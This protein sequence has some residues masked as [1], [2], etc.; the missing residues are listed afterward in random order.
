MV[1]FRKRLTGK[2]AKKPTD[3]VSLYATLDRAHDKGPLRPAQEAVLG[4]WFAKRQSERDVIIKLH[5]GQGKTL[6]G[7]LML[8]SRLNAG[9]GPVVY[10]CP[11]NFLIEQTEEQARQFGI[12]T[13]AADGELP[14]AFLNADPDANSAFGGTRHGP[15][16]TR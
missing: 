6:I 1:D 12:K 16:R 15:Q 5:T 11:N 10:L 13:C 14:A 8:Q 2:A 7:L 4:Q 9:H 3:P